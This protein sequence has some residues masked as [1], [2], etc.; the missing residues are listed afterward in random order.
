M[1]K[2]C[3]INY[4]PYINI[5][6]YAYMCKYMFVYTLLKQIPDEICT[7]DMTRNQEFVDLIDR[8]SFI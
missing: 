2:K 3:K 6:V 1:V 4:I 8:C 7:K 5:Y